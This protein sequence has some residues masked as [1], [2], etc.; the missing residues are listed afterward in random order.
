MKIVFFTFY[1]P[2][3]LSAGSFRSVALAQ[4]LSRKIDSNDELHV[5]TTHPNRYASYREAANN[6]ELDGNITIHR[7]L[8]P[9]HR[10]GMLSQTR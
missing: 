6:I 7:I 10:S 2:P 1:Y 5:I 4:A 8:A 9:S 3:D